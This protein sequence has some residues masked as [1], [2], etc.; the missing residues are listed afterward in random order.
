[1]KS[2]LA[3]SAALILLSGCL[4]YDI[5]Q[6]NMFSDEDGNIVQVDY[7]H[8][9]RDHVHVFRSPV[10]GQEMEFKSKL[11]VRVHLPDGDAF[12]AWQCMNFVNMGTMYKTDDAEWMFLANGFTCIVYAQDENDPIRYNEV[13][14]GVICDAPKTK[15][16]TNDKWRT[17]K[18]DA[19]GKWK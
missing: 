2:V 15:V 18:K 6:T 1:M 5:V 3:I 10:N 17:M 16:K 8:S 9:E 11:L 12:K 4:S 7:G 13:Y 14:K 19:D